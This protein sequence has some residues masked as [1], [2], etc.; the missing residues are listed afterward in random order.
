MGD[1][2]ARA[3]ME[4]PHRLRLRCFTDRQQNTLK[5]FHHL[6]IREANHPISISPEPI[7]PV[8][9]HLT[10]MRVA[11]DFDNEGEASANEVAY[12]SVD[13]DL[14]GELETVEP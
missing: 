3:A 7:I 6:R 1:A 12:T 11:I 10:I 4:M 8:G 9:V 2:M 13:R 5:I 14:T